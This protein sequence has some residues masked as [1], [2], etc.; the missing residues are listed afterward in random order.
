[1]NRGLLVRSNSLKLKRLNDG[2][3]TNMQLFSSQDI[4]DGLEWCV[5]LWCFYPLFGLSFW[6]HPFTAELWWA[7]DVTLH[8]SKSDEETNSS[9]SWPE[10]EYIFILWVKY[11]FKMSLGLNTVLLTWDACRTWWVETHPQEASWISVLRWGASELPEERWHKTAS[12]RSNQRTPGS[13]HS[14]LQLPPQGSPSSCPG[15]CNRSPQQLKTPGGVLYL[16]WVLRL[17]YT[18]IFEISIPYNCS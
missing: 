13:S 16:G 3:V 4:T 8:F 6:R 7:S 14:P 11:S 18:C 9:T 5:L 1:M 12:S 17:D 10:R 2:F 15:I